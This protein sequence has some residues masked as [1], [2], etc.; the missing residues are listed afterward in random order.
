MRYR[1][2]LRSVYN[3]AE[4]TAKI[5]TPATDQLAFHFLTTEF[6]YLGLSDKFANR[7]FV[8][9]TANA[10]AAT[11]AVKYWNGTTWAAVEDL[12]DETVGLTKNGW[13]GWKN[14]SDWVKST[15]S[16]I[17]DV[18]LFWVR[19]TT[20]TSLDSGTEVQAIL[21]LL[22]DDFLMRTWYPEFISDDRYL[23]EGR[24]DFYEQYDAAKNL[25][26]QEL[27]RMNA[28]SKESEI[29]DIAE[30]GVAATHAAAYCIMS[31]IPNKTEAQI[32]T[33]DK[34]FEDMIFWVQK[35]KTSFDTDDSGAIEVSEEQI[36]PRYIPRGGY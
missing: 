25:V 13:L 2:Q 5:A 3:S 20:G 27:I 29:L 11:L 18:E 22:S 21:N 24:T 7:Y 4:V 10:T 26:V 6:L 12:V 8:M 1:N 9:K 23:P 14:K 15:V 17:T 33:R 32:A 36:A 28:I 31:G 35:A 16:P 19:I 34:M 30:L